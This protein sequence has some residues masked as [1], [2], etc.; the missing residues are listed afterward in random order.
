MLRGYVDLIGPTRLSGWALD[1]ADL[2]R[3]INVD[4]IVNGIQYAAPRADVLREDLQRELGFGHHA[5]VFEFNPPLPLL[6]EHRVV[7]RYGGTDQVVPNGERTLPAVA[8]DRQR[9]LQPILVTAPGR[10][11]STILMKRL[12][13][14]P[15]VSVADLYPF[16]TEL[17][18]YYSHAFRILTSPGDHDRS[19]KPETFVDNHRFL[20]A[21]PYN[22][23]SF[24]K[25]F[26]DQ[27][28]FETFYETVVPREMAAAF[29]RIVTEFYE[30]VAADQGKVMPMFFA[31][32]CQLASLARW[33]ARSLFSDVREIVLVRDARDTMCS[34]RSFWS[35]STAEAIRLLR[36]ACDTLMTVRRE[37]R[38]DVLFLRYEDMVAQETDHLR[39]V[40]AFVGI[41]DF[42]ASDATSEQALFKEH[43]T[44]KSPQ[45]SIGRWKRELSAEEVKLCMAEF[46][47][48]LE[49]FGYDV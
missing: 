33:F 22:V 9:L 5:F 2:R 13:A 49:M 39:R 15:A 1:D 26:K 3:P 35:Q 24:G 11:G 44:S 29:R 34:Y 31:E 47:P 8:L 10:G 27:G 7:V 46:T 4:V 20:G 6:R 23:A 16:E 41:R 28:R 32:K 18:K 14:H 37:E 19:G 42:A 38:D 17:L 25:A 40:A 21:N 48:Y 36:L 30:A 43:A 45:A 12:A